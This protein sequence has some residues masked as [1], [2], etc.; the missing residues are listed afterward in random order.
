MVHVHVQGA[1][2]CPWCLSMSM[3]H[4]RVHG[5]C[6]CSCCMTMSM[7]HG[8]VHAECL[9]PFCMS[10]S[11]LYFHI[12][13]VIPCLRPRCMSISMSMLYVYVHSAHPYPC[14]TFRSRLQVHSSCCMHIQT[15]VCFHGHSIDMEL[16]TRTWT[17]K[18]T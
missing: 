14:Y 16:G 4:V 11:M 2:P 15:T 9:C 17:R 3:V 8:H 12:H 1:C 18:W 6:P 5:T 10:M 13:A 7:L